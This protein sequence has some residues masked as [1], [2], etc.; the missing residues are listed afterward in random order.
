M[1]V[2]PSSVI[3][4]SV[5]VAVVVVVVV[6]A[7]VVVQRVCCTHRN[8]V[9]GRCPFFEKFVF[10]KRGMPSLQWPVHIHTLNFIVKKIKNLKELEIYQS[11]QNEV[12][13]AMIGKKLT[14][15]NVLPWWEAI[16]RE[17]KTRTTARKTCNGRA[18]LFRYILSWPLTGFTYV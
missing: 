4:V 16:L 6:D 18:C 5:A 8:T 3:L 1:D 12:A 14:K 7:V 2:W 11:H 17:S 9:T 10:S 15:T 13:M